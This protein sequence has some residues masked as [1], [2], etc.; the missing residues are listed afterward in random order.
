MLFIRSEISNINF[1]SYLQHFTLYR[2]LFLRMT[3]NGDYNLNLLSR[4]IIPRYQ[5]FFACYAATLSN[6]QKELIGTDF[7]LAL[8]STHNVFFF[9]DRTDSNCCCFGVT[10]KADGPDTSTSLDIAT[11]WLCRWEMLVGWLGKGG[12]TATSYFG[13][14]EWLLPN[15][16][17][18][19]WINWIN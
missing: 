18:I 13:D 11:R 19:L 2:R 17:H 1:T 9:R 16:G 8:R 12:P 6:L 7:C 5:P 4:K 3:A 15:I 14:Y 10:F